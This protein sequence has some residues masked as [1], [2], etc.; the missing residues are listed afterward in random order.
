M[1]SLIVRQSLKGTSSPKKQKSTNIL[2][3]VEDCERTGQ[4][5]LDV[6]GMNLNNW[7][8]EVSIL[9]S[10][11]VLK[12]FNNKLVEFPSLLNL[13]WLEI[14]DLSRNSITSMADSNISQLFK[15]K[16]LDLSRNS[17]ENLP[18]DICLLQLLE[19]LILSRNMLKTL[20][21]NLKSLK[22]LRSLDLSFNLLNRIGNCLDGLNNLEELNMSDNPDLDLDGVEARIRRIN[23]KRNIMASKSARRALITRAL[24]IQRDVLTHEQQLIFRE[25]FASQ[26]SGDLSAHP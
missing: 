1:T 20:P 12:G 17:I 26:K 23:E 19:V 15:L 24:S 21:A 4:Y 9:T 10:V 5:L 22:S 8:C 18:E 13:R 11:K 7:P 2:D 16:T 14:V 25:T 6:S 3:R